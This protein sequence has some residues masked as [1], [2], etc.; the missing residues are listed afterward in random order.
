MTNE[1]KTVVCKTDNFVLF[2]VPEL[3]HRHRTTRQVHLQVQYQSEVTEELQEKKKD[4]SRDSDD[5]LRDLPDCLEEFT[6]NLEDTELSASVHSSQ[7]SDSE[8]PTK[9]I[10]RSRMHCIKTQTEIAKS[11]C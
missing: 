10:S 8:R 3:L 1:G 2:V 9:V 11:A 5:R 7:D 6:D 4:D